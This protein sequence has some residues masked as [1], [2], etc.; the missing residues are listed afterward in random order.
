V[1]AVRTS[2]RK[3]TFKGADGKLGAESAE[4]KRKEV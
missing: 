2:K 3:A 1:E 4:K